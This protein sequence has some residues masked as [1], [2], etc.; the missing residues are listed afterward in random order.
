MCG[1]WAIPLALVAAGSVAKYFGNQQ[2]QHARERTFSAERQRQQA[3]TEQQTARFQDSL[4]KT[5]DL[6][7]KDK[8]A[9]AAQ[10]R[11][12]ALTANMIPE[13]QGAY[14]P[15]SSSAPNI[16]Q[17]ASD[18]AAAG[19]RER[20]QSLAHALAA[21]GGTTDQLQGV[22]I[23]VGRDAQQ[24]GQLGGFKAGS[25]NVLD[26]EMRAA[27]HKGAFL[28]GIG[29]LAQ[30]IGQAWLGASAGAGLV[31]GG[32]SVVSAPASSS[33]SSAFAGVPV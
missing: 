30:T 8:V 15:G 2:A 16:V 23:G 14:L 27:A 17:T 25:A 3:M 18:D 4:D 22:N 7:D 6:L 28:R 32:G 19:S 26:A 29:G 31:G 20:G 13:G 9:E 10:S 5:K 33:M 21:L 24:I 11:E 1:P 12:D